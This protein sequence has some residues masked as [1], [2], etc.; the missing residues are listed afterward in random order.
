MTPD[1]VEVQ[2]LGELHKLRVRAEARR[3][4]DDERAAELFAGFDVS[5]PD[6]ILARP[7]EPPAGLGPG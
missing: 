3:R 2:V 7:E 5:T 1:L 6:Q 4:Y